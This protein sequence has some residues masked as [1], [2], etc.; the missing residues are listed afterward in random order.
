MIKEDK[1]ITPKDYD[2][3][4]K[5]T[6]VLVDDRV[7]EIA[8]LC[9]SFENGVDLG[10]GTGGLA[11]L[12]QMLV[13]D[14]SPVA[15]KRA[16]ELGFTVEQ[17]NILDFLRTDRKFDLVVLGDVLEEM[18]E[19]ETNAL[20]DGIAKICTKYFVISTPTHENYLQ[21]HT[22]QVIYSKDELIKMIED[23]GFTLEEKLNYSDRLIARFLKI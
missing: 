16:K 14:W 17:K 4:W 8:N 20:L 3:Y 15:C 22:H 13:V 23:R 21:M 12:R 10:G 6:G 9:P 2:S 11:T 1:G 18:R 19:D 7:K 5:D